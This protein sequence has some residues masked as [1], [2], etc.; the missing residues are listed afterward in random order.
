MHVNWVLKYGQP[1]NAMKVH[2]KV[3]SANILLELRS[4]F[5]VV[6]YHA[7]TLFAF[8]FSRL[9]YQIQYAKLNQRN[10]PGISFLMLQTINI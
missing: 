4:G 5:R 8:F 2:H 1:Q 3:I 10:Y 7:I 9:C 6:Y